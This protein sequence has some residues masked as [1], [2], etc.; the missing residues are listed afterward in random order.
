MAYQWFYGVANSGIP[1]TLI[2]ASGTPA[3]GYN[4][5]FLSTVLS[6]DGQAWGSVS[7]RLSG[8]PGDGVYTL[9]SLSSTEMT[10]FY[11]TVKVT[12][13]SG[14]LPQVIAGYNLSG[15][16]TAINVSGLPGLAT[17]VSNI[18]L[19]MSGHARRID[20]SALDGTLT[21]ASGPVVL[22]GITHTNALVGLWGSSHTS[23][24]IARVTD[25]TNAGAPPVI[26]ISSIASQVWNSLTTTYASSPTFGGAVMV[27]GKLATVSGLD[28]IVTAASGNDKILTAVSNVP[29]AAGS[30]VAGIQTTDATVLTSGTLAHDAR[31]IRH[32]TWNNMFI[33]KT[34]TPYRQ[35]HYNGTNMS[36]WFDIEDDSN[37]AKRTRSG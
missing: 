30:S 29:V 12:S 31:M 26:D 1:I 25:L 23:S 19:D 35:Y 11:W 24:L 37:T 3:I 28:N 20:V 16:A 7:G 32:F 21:A 17:N 5:V 36:S 34:Y 33:D 9:A 4:P 10:C 15:Y 13:N 2:T 27:S 6:K 8:I 22:R 14:C 18:G